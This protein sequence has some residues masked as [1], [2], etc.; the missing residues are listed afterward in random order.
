M[1][2]E[3]INKLNPMQKQAVLTTEGPL[4]LLAGAGSGKTRVLTHRIAYLIEKGVRPFNILAIT[5]TNKAAREMKERVAAISPQGDEVWVSTFHSTCVRLL[6]REIDKIGYTNQFSIYDAD[7]SER[8]IKNILKEM[9]VSDKQYPVK[10]VISEIGSLKDNL[11]KPDEFMSMVEKDFRKKKIAEVYQIYQKRLA[12]N[13]ALD[14]DDLIFKTVDLF[15]QRPD[16]LEKY[17]ERFKYILV[18]EYQDTNTSQYMLVKMLAAKYNNLCVV[19]DDDQSIY[20]WRGANIRN[21]LDFEKDFPSAQ[22]I[23]LEQNYRSTQIILD[24]ANTVIRHNQNRKTK[25]LWTEQ[26]G[27]EKIRYYHGTNDYD[28]ARYICEE[29]QKGKKNGGNY[30]D[31]AILYRNNA[32]SRVLEEQLVRNAIP[33][34]LF[35]GTRFYDR[36][37]IKDILAYLKIIYNPSDDIAIRRIINV[38]KRGIGDTSVTRIAAYAAENDMSFFMALCDCNAVPG[39]TARTYNSLVDF[40]SMLNDF[41]ADAQ[42]MTVSQI[43]NE[44]LERTGYCD[45]LRLENTTEAEGRL[46]NLSELINKASD[47]EAQNPE[48]PSLGGFLQEVSLVADVD[49]F[50]EDQDTVV[51][52]TL[53]S[54]KGLEFPTVFIA[55]FEET[56]FPGYRAFMAGPESSEMEEERR[57]C[58]V[59]ITRAKEKLYLTSAQARLQHGQRVYNRPSRFLKEIP[60]TFILENKPVVPKEVVDKSFG[61]DTYKL[62][63]NF[64]T[65]KETTGSFEIDFEVG[66]T[67]KHLKFGKGKI[68][69]INGEGEDTEMSVEF[70]RLGTRKFKKKLFCFLKK[71]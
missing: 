22:V 46:E 44:V 54:S 10:A 25:K 56:I 69:A 5:F 34:R 18:D 66:D 8:L 24:A 6:R 42:E 55:G 53:H 30:S 1:L 4:L 71:V 31:F 41:K 64:T 3:M 9:N 58:Y 7:D 13:N 45:S 33:Y 29:I 27:G 59:G 16:V 19:G 26:D 43:I 50:T 28:E 68:T 48:D 11:I 61:N 14:F 40:C 12:D 21:I 47:Y 63:T 23:K 70:E 51:L 60:P 35:G 65:K 17:Q 57:L 20:G 38:P 36:K 49:A 67:V 52:M 62:K 37:E 32:L 39:L 2:Q 15:K